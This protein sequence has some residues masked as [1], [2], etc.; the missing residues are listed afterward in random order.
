MNQALLDQLKTSP[1]LPS[2]PA[3]AIKALELARQENVS[4]TEIAD[5]ISN[6][7]AL[8]SKILKTV[9]SSF[10]G[11]PKEVSTISR[12]LVIL[13]LQAVKTLALGF[14]LLTNL[15]NGP[16]EGFDYMVFWKRS[17]YSAVAAKLLAK[18]LRVVQQE[19]AFLCGLLADVG[20]IVMHRV[21]GADY[22]AV[23]AASNGDQEILA[24]MSMEKFDLDHTTVGGMLAELWQLPP[25][26]AKPIA[27]HHN[28][29]EPD[30]QLRPLV[31]TV[32]VAMICG[33][34]FSNPNP[35]KYV[36]QARSELA[37]RCKLPPVEIE[38]LLSEIGK[39]TREAAKLFEVNI[40][41]NRSYQDILDEANQ[42]LVQ[43]TLQSQQQVTQVRKENVQLPGQGHDRSR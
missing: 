25:V 8:S 36:L 6:D 33:E 5:L 3:I 26:L 1:Q 13:G 20:I 16:Q 43:L 15:K 40:G 34:V 42:A 10:Y 22:D 38:E 4:I 29:N 28:P 12:A 27:Q 32:F 19:E 39:H 11:L 9:N 35:A 30:A 18:K 17:I 21:V 23:V 24:Q 31:E 37:T 14:S 2:L 7:P 41:P